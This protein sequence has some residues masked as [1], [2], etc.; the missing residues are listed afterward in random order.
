MKLESKKIALFC[1]VLIFASIFSCEPSNKTT[2]NSNSDTTQIVDSSTLKYDRKFNDM[3]LWLAGIPQD[4]NGTYKKFENNQVWKDYSK[5]ITEAFDKF[6]EQRVTKLT[7]FR[8]NYLKEVN[9]NIKTL[10]YPYSGP[11][12]INANIFFPK[13]DTIIMIAL[14]PVGNIPDFETFTEEKKSNY[15]N[16][17][18]ASMS[19]VLDAGYFITSEMQ[20]KYDNK[21]NDSIK[22]VLPI[23]YI[24][25][26][27]SGCQIADVQ[28]FTIDKL[29]KPVDSLPNTVDLDNPED[30]YVSAVKIDYFK[31]NKDSIKTL[32]Y[33]S[34]NIREAKIKNNLEFITFLKNRT[35]NTT[36]L[37]AASYLNIWFETIRNV[38]L[39]KSDYILQDDS[40]I[41]IKYFKKSI[42]EIQLFGTYTRTLKMFKA[43]FQSDLRDMYKESKNTIA[44]DFKTGYNGNF[45]KSN[46]QLAK[47]ISSTQKTKP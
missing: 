40:G 26:A 13:A 29:G 10:F 39:E 7:S 30:T 35:I 32:M 20:E 28:R 45:K 14:E 25:M 9:E 17:M 2:E 41:P 42:W 4:K 1:L 15:F 36:Y 47:K 44:L 5:N 46:L 18:I 38:S 24:F 3:A 31:E 21:S 12:F 27:K 23:L 8:K 37:K 11:D 16:Q 22:G 33:F 34:H 6:K 19:N 43:Y